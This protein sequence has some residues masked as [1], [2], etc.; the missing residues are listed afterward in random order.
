[1]KKRT[2]AKID[3]EFK[4]FV[5]GLFQNFEKMTIQLKS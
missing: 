1:M 2:Q 4:I 5:W 3:F